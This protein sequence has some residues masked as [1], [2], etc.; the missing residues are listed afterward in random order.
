MSQEELKAC[1]FCG[2]EAHINVIRHHPVGECKICGV[3]SPWAKTV[4]QA[5]ESW[6]KRADLPATKEQA[7]T[8]EFALRFY[9]AGFSMGQED[10]GPGFDVMWERHAPAIVDKTGDRDYCPTC[11]KETCF[12]H[13]K[14]GWACEHC[15]QVKIAASEKEGEK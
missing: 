11:E 14:L 10:K 3:L 2:G 12:A 9:N 1:P 5:I 6:N 8:K 15:W 4:P 7:V 13:R